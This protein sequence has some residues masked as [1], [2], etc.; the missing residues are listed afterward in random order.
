MSNIIR[1]L[2]RYKNS[3]GIKRNRNGKALS[4][5]FVAIKLIKKASDSCK[6]FLYF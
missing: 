5:D 2:A 1:F 3:S 6:I 4:E